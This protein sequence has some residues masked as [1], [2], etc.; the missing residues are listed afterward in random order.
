[1]LAVFGGNGD[2][3]PTYADYTALSAAVSSGELVDGDIAKTEN[4]DSYFFVEYSRARPVV[5][6]S[7]ELPASV[8]LAWEIETL[9]QWGGPDGNSLAD[10]QRIGFWPALRGGF[11]FVMANPNAQP[12]FR[13]TAAADGGPCVSF[14]NSSATFLDAPTGLITGPITQVGFLELRNTLTQRSIWDSAGAASQRQHLFVDL[15]PELAL[16]V[17]AVAKTASPAVPPANT[18]VMIATYHDG[19][20]SFIRVN[21]TSSALLNPGA[22]VETFGLRLGAN[23]NPSFYGDFRLKGYYVGQGLID[24]DEMQ[25]YGAKYSIPAP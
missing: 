14:R 13:T 9:E 22:G 17:T 11:P 6:D 2:E 8:D 3:V 4:T 12:Y 1:M 10:N 20:N 15:G 18:L 19:S 16:Y 24:L 7:A 25:T 23:T 5:P 21:S